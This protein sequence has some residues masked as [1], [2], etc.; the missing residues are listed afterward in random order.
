MV[1]IHSAT[2][3]IRREKKKDRRRR[4]RRK[5]PERKNI[6][7]CP[8]PYRAA[9]IT[10]S[11]A[12]YSYNYIVHYCR[13]ELP[14]RPAGVHIIRPHRSASAMYEDAAYCYRRSSAVC[15]SAGRSVTI[16]SPAKTAE[17]FEMIFELW[18]LV[19]PSDNVLNGGPDPARE[20]AILSGNEQ[21]IVKYR[22]YR[23]CAAVM[24]PFVKLI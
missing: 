5:K 21:P 9:I 15:L 16:V 18:T 24:R 10:V 19:G 6:M 4:R 20:R 22:E 1:D 14:C 12:N 17:P 11:D 2:A 23:P 13:S 8:I 3:E 7:A